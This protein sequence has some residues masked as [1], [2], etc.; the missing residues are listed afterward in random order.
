MLIS[1]SN[2]FGSLLEQD[3]QEAIEQ[4]TLAPYALH[5]VPI[6]TD[7]TWRQIDHLL[8]LPHKVVFIEAKNTSADK[9]KVTDN[10]D[11]L[12]YNK[13][14]GDYGKSII[15]QTM[16]TKTILDGIINTP[17]PVDYYNRGMSSFSTHSTPIIPIGCI[18][19]DTLINQQTNIAIYKDTDLSI[20]LKSLELEI[21][22]FSQDYLDTHFAFHRLSLTNFLRTPEQYINHLKE[23]G[24][25]NNNPLYLQETTNLNRKLDD[26]HNRLLTSK[27]NTITNNNEKRNQRLQI[28]YYLLKQELPALPYNYIDYTLKYAV[29]QPSEIALYFVTLESFHQK[30]KNQYRFINLILDEN[31]HLINGRYILN[32]LNRYNIYFVEFLYALV[33]YYRE[34]HPDS[35]NNLINQTRKPYEKHIDFGRVIHFILYGK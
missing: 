4:T 3:I 26:E 13:H 17:K 35:Y 34:K 27:P 2:T 8:L 14:E 11:T 29:A 15:K 12:F 33:D 24:V 28:V 31:S 5:N 7:S 23:S 32:Q 19:V 22:N 16:K 9:Y 30:T 10:K 1:D 20:F 25:Y 21:A 18:R 6:Q